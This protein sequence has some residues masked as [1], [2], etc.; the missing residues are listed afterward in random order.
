MEYNILKKLDED[1]NILLQ[2]LNR[3][4]RRVGGSEYG[5][6]LYDDRVM[7][8]LEKDVMDW[9]NDLVDEGKLTEGGSR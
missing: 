5:L 7:D 1:F 3:T 8:A 2:T 6:P 4:A 9:I